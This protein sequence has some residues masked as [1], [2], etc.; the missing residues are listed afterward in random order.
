[1]K[2][3]RN[4]PCH[5]G[6]GKKYKKCCLAKDEAAGRERARVQ[7]V[8]AP[9][10][11]VLLPA[12]TPPPLPEPPTPPPDP[13][14]QERSALWEEFED[15]KLD[16]LTEIF[17]R[18]LENPELMDEEFAF[19]ML[20]A[21][22]DRHS[23]AA[24]H[25]ALKAL[26]EQR[27]DLYEHDAAYYLDWQI[28]DALAAGYSDRLPELCRS[29]ADTA[30]K[31]LDE[32]YTTLELLLY[33]GQLAP[34]SEM[35]RR[36]WPL[37]RK[38]KDYFPGATDELASR[39]QDLSALAYLEHA[40][41][42][43]ADDPQLTT[44]LEEV[45][46][47]DPSRLAE[48]IALV[49]GLSRRTWSLDDVAI[50][51]SSDREKKPDPAH[52]QLIDLTLAFIG[53]A[54]REDGIPLSRSDL[55][56]ISLIEY[57]VQRHDGKLSDKGQRPRPSAQARKGKGILQPEPTNLLLP[58]YSTLDRHLASFLGFLSAKPYAA[59]ATLE[60]LPAWLRFLESRALITPE[61]RAAALA[62]LR[63]LVHQAEGIW[64]ERSDGAVL[65]A[66]IR[67]EWE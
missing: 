44:V 14:D 42:P 60:L 16:R 37:V 54:W 18:T 34:A 4:E 57:I 10:F 24:F 51:T 39:A 11:P 27:P 19:E 59:A 50:R 35:L 15:A 47:I 30:G 55:G 66:N 1:M 13:L 32:I 23:I 46:S 3:G 7:H 22:R 43:A 21:I 64:K 49:A 33:H 62:D 2:L 65:A 6:S 20:M 9:A 31:H 28:A 63:P 38:S 53:E 25:E 45:D 48:Y 56:R 8:A 41:Y 61:Q 17:L 58:D 52:L 12:H 26:I 36:A 40:D 29:L 67:R 5:C